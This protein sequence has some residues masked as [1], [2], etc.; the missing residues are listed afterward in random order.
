MGAVSRCI[1]DSDRFEHGFG[2]TIRGLVH[3]TTITVGVAF[4]RFFLVILRLRAR[5]PVLT[6]TLVLVP[7]NSFHTYTYLSGRRRYWRRWRAFSMPLL[8]VWPRAGAFAGARAVLPPPPCA[9]S[10]QLLQCELYMI[11]DA[12]VFMSARGPREKRITSDK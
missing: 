11:Y 12:Y 1:L 8:V 10:A 9:Q 6:V 4:I 2:D 3:N 5:S 7:P